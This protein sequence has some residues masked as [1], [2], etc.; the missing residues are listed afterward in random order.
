[1]NKKI[2][3]IAVLG[4][5]LLTSI[6]TV[7]ISGMPIEVENKKG[8]SEE[9]LTTLNDNHEK[10]NPEWYKFWIK[11][12]DAPPL[13][14]NQYV[15]KH[16]HIVID[17]VNGLIYT[18]GEGHTMISIGYKANY[19]LQ[20]DLGS[21]DLLNYKT[22]I[23]EEESSLAPNSPVICSKNG[24]I[25]VARTSP[26]EECLIV[27]KYDK[28]LDDAIWSNQVFH[29]NNEPWRSEPATMIIDS[30]NN[31]YIAG[32]CAFDEYMSRTS[33]VIKIKDDGNSA[34]VKWRDF[35][36][37]NIPG[38]CSGLPIGLKSLVVHNGY[39]YACGWFERVADENSDDLWILKYDISTGERVKET[40]WNLEDEMHVFGELGKS[41]MCFNN[42]LYVFGYIMTC[43]LGVSAAAMWKYD[44]ELNLIDDTPKIILDECDRNHVSE[45]VK[46]GDYFYVVGFLEENVGP[47]SWLPILF[48]SKYDFNGDMVWDSCKTWAY[49][50]FS[51]ASEGFSIAAYNNNLYIG[52]RELSGLSNHW[53]DA[54]LLKCNLE[55]G[56]SGS[57]SDSKMKYSNILDKFPLFSRLLGH[58]SIFNNLKIIK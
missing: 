1:M 50:K 24:Y 13:T 35:Q 49:G 11:E 15:H 12:P 26:N 55:G 47:G 39:L 40:F 4:I 20:Y 29:E 42:N 37:H 54:F 34:D 58:F 18:A 3:V 8:N 57:S 43:P 52:G 17:D 2:I 25:Y 9:I 31:L 5:L 7:S 19:L 6:S 21:E 44:L 23:W 48:I 27:E 36:E 14:D 28:N 32:M 38:L 41:V 56:H 10:I 51:S 33:F 53:G 30:N 16:E 45:V 46:Y 22:W